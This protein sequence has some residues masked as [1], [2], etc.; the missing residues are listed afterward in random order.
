MEEKLIELLKLCRKAHSK[1]IDIELE[2]G[3][4]D[5]RMYHFKNGKIVKH[6]AAIFAL[7]YA[8]NQIDD[9]VNYLKGLV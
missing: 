9:I 2:F 1:N 8:D 3:L 7:S 4:S 5:V 6:L